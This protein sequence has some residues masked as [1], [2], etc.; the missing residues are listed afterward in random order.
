MHHLA[1]VTLSGRPNFPYH[2]SCVC[3]P[4]G[5]FGTKQAAM[6][7]IA[8]HFVRQQGIN[9]AEFVDETGE[10]DPSAQAPAPQ[11]PVEQEFHSI[12]SALSPEAKAEFDAQMKKAA[13][14]ILT[15]SKTSVEGAAG[16][17]G[18]AST[19]VPPSPDPEKTTGGEGAA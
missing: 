18:Q 8:M 12:Y 19:P 17:E 10:I 7:Y 13:I 14:D 4:S 2:A 5:D 16:G 6:D 1:K 3:G 15:K 9:S 11:D